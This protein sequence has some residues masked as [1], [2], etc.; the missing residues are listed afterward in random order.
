MTK[1]EIQEQYEEALPKYRAI[2][3]KFGLVDKDIAFMFCYKNLNSFSTAQDGRKKTIIGFVRTY[4]VFLNQLKVDIS[5]RG[6]A[7]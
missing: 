7:K 6:K 4:E 2:K 1:E 3:A 5:E